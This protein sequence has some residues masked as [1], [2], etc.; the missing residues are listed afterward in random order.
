MVTSWFLNLK[1]KFT[2]TQHLHTLLACVF[3]KI[4]LTSIIVKLIIMMSW[5]KHKPKYNR[6][7]YKKPPKPFAK[8]TK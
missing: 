2:D 6:L 1:Q 3:F 5:S 7:S 8:S 4:S